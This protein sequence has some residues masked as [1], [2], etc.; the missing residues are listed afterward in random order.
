MTAWLEENKLGQKKINFK[1][2]DW[3]FSRQRY[4][5]EPIPIVHCEKCGA[6][7]VPEEQLPVRLPEVEKYEPTGTGE[8]PLANIADWVNTTCPKCGGP[9]KR[10]TNTMPQWAGSSW[11]YLR[12]IDPKNEKFLIDQ[13]L[14]KDWMPVDLYVGG[15]EHATR[16]LLYARFW[17]KFLFDIGVVTTIEPFKKLMHVGLILAEDGRKMSK[18]WNNV[19]NPD[20]VIGQFGADSMRLYEM[21]MGPFSQSI[22]WNTNGVVGMRKFLEK[23]WKLSAQINTEEGRINTET[24]NNKKIQTLLHKTIK[25][26]TEDI[27]NFRF[28]TALSQLMILVNAMEKEYAKSA[29]TKAHMRKEDYEKLLLIL[30]PFAPHLAEELWQKL[31]NENSIFLQTWPVADEKYLKDEEIEMVV[32][33]NG[34]VRER[35]LVA[36]DVTE[37]EVKETALENEKVKI[38]TDGKE[39]KKII[40][41]PEK[42]INIVVN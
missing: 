11:Y 42:L 39:I 22:S 29:T 41:V 10:E 18:R 7:G 9:A 15:A 17:H 8:S 33:V 35:L 20:E 4:W 26:V 1:M 6:V 2:R 32:Q 25:K 34:K 36:I 30:S 12:Y 19:I 38:F 5:G 21:F 37:D 14:E 31:G 3:I 40:F 13:Q 16:H 23:V 24:Q 28:N 27:E